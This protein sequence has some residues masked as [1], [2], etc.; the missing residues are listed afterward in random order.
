MKKR[1]HVLRVKHPYWHWVVRKGRKN[2]T[3]KGRAT[4]FAT[5]DEAEYVAKKLRGIC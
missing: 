5:K 1:I 2:V 3:L 4:R